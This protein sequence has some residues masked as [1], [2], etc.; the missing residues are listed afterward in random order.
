MATPRTP[1][2]AARDTPTAAPLALNVP[3]GMSPSSFITS[4]GTPAAAPNRGSGTSGVMPSPMD[5]TR[6]GSRTGSSSW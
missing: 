5:T 3:V 1:S 6:S 4:R 2:S